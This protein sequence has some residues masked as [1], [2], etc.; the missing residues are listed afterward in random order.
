MEAEGLTADSQSAK[1]LILGWIRMVKMFDTSLRYYFPKAIDIFLKL[2]IQH[3]YGLL[4]FFTEDIKSSKLTNKIQD[5]TQYVDVMR[6]ILFYYTGSK[7]F[8]QPNREE[9]CSLLGR[10]CRSSIFKQ[11]NAC[12]EDFKSELEAI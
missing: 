2:S 9:F 6:S 10:Y 8:G 7:D 4:K 11:I 3:Q 12:A 5:N 1:N